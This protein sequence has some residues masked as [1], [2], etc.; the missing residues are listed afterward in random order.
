MSLRKLASV[1]MH[2]RFKGTL[3]FRIKIANFQL[4]VGSVSRSP[5]INRAQRLPFSSTLMIHPRVEELHRRYCLQ[6]KCGGT[7][8]S[9]DK[10]LTFLSNILP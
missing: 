8:Q 4:I 5:R 7:Q 10:V 9:W 6:T 1:R 3:R 2:S